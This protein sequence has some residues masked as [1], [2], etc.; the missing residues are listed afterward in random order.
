MPSQRF[1]K[2]SMSILLAYLAIVIGLELLRSLT[3]LPIVATLAASPLALAH[4]DWWRLITSAFIIDGYALPQVVM[5]ATLGALIIWFR[6]SWLFWGISVA[7]HVLGTL[8]TYLGVLLIGLNRH[9]LHHFLETPDYGISLIWSSAL[10]VV[11]AAAWLGPTSNF[12]APFRPLVVCGVFALMMVIIFLS[13][14][15]DALQHAIAFAVGAV[16]VVTLDR[17]HSVSQQPVLRHER[18]A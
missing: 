14:G 5:T 3:N 1:S 8:L 16:L 2:T 6:G 13:H 7:G 4:G 10:G 12:R 9:Q 11:A 17:D 15:D 18:A